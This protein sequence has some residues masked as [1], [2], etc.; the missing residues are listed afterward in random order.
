MRSQHLLVLLLVL[1]FTNFQ[2]ST[3]TVHRAPRRQSRSMSSLTSGTRRRSKTPSRCRGLVANV[4]LLLI[5]TVGRG[6]IGPAAVVVTLSWSWL[7]E[8]GEDYIGNPQ[9][10]G[11]MQEIL[12]W[13][14][15]PM[16]SFPSD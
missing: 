15:G 8:R 3:S 7:W 9:D 10:V 1:R 16:F 4:A 14:R 5:P 12:R 13:R 6:R 11:W 2:I